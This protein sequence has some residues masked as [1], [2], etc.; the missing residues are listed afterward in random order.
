MSAIETFG[1]SLPGLVFESVVDPKNAGRLVLHAWNGDRFTTAGSIEHAGVSY[2]P[3]K[4]ESGLAQSVRFAPPSLPFGSTVKLIS[5]LRDF[6]STHLRLQPDVTVLLVAFG[7]ATWFCDLMPVAPALYLFG[8]DTAITQV[9]RA[10]ACFCRRPVLLGD[11]DSGGLATLPNRLGATLLINQRDLGRRVRRTLLASARRDFCVIRGKQCLDIYGARA[12]SSDDF[13]ERELGLT[14]SVSPSQGPQPFDSVLAQNLQRKMLRYRLVNYEC[15]REQSIDVSAF[16]PEMREQASTWLA[17][18]VDCPELSESVYAEILR[19]SQEV[20]GARFFDPKCVVAEVA[21]FFC[22]KPDTTHFF[23]G[24]LAKK[25]NDLLKGQHEEWSLTNRKAGSLLRDL[26]IFGKRVAAGFEIAVTDAV[27]E[28]IHQL[29]FDYQ[30]PAACD[31]VRRCRYCR[32][33]PAS[34]EAG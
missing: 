6:L 21:L 31:G 11:I 1:E 23:V 7:L 12:L 16:A 14:A 32:E 28:Q 2:V 24:E 8:P 29:A 33:I 20:A 26:G 5:C 4:L 9:F 15:V 17:P 10:L 18:I 27:R 22:H 19:Q 3:K 34:P 13:L 25:V 30:V